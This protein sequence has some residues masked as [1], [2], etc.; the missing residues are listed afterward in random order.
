M[1]AKDR[2]EI[3]PFGNG[4]FRVLLHYGYQDTPH[5]PL[6]LSQISCDEYEFIAAS[7]S[8]FIGRDAVILKSNEPR[9]KQW[10]NKAFAFMHRN[11]SS[12]SDYL[13]LPSNAVVELG[14]LVEI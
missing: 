5:V 9:F 13:R 6:H 3:Y 4:C 14:G 8:Y 12:I 1:P 2:V 10:Q 7:T 11:S